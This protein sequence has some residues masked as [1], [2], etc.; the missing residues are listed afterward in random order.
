MRILMVTIL[1]MVTSSLALAQTTGTDYPGRDKDEK[2]IKRVMMQLEEAWNKHDAD[3][4]SSLFRPDA[5]FTSWKGER[6][7]GRESIRRFL[8]PL[9]KNILK[10]STLKSTHN[11]IQFYGQDIATVDG[12]WEMTGLLDQNLKPIPDKKDIPLF[13]VRKEEGTWLIAAMHNV[14]LQPL[15]P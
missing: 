8:A 12:E 9:F 15:C 2:A 6:A 1:T 13:V 10:Q 5:D 7:Q 4:Y 14:L 3:A 11:R